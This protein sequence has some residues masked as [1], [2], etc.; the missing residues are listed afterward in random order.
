M[1]HSVAFVDWLKAN[2]SQVSPKVGIKDYSSEGARLGLSAVEDIRQGEVLFTVPRACLLTRKTCKHRDMVSKLCSRQGW[3]P[4]MWAI[5]LE[6]IDNGDSFWKPYFDV[7]PDWIDLPST[8]S[9]D[10]QAQR[11]CGTGLDSLI[12]ETGGQFKKFFLA[13]KDAFPQTRSLSVGEFERLFHFAGS[14]ISAYSFTEDAGRIEDIAIVPLADILNHRTGCNNARLFYGADALK[15]VCIRDVSA[16]EQLFN[17]YGD[18]PNSQ[19]LIKYGYVDWKNPFNLVHFNLDWLID[20]VK[21]QGKDQAPRLVDSNRTVEALADAYCDE[22]E[23]TIDAK[24]ECD[25]TG[26]KRLFHW[27]HLLTLPKG[28]LPKQWK[29]KKQYNAAWIQRNLE[30]IVRILQ[31]RIRLYPMERV[32]DAETIEQ[33]PCGAERYVAT[34]IYQ[35]IEALKGYIDLLQSPGVLDA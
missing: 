24:E 20:N 1:E 16:G 9:K 8:W 19:L 15:M 7:V 33:L 25:F 10:E 13:R 31:D 23:L 5:I 14:L 22:I 12:P 6:R 29:L 21:S 2:G 27:I 11:L 35:D 28:T 30:M 18:L 17:T 26:L 32:L 4:L 34:I 3:V